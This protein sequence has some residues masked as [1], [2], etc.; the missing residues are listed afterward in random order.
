MRTKNKK[1]TV[2]ILALVPVFALAA[3]LVVSSLTTS[4]VQ[5]V[6]AQGFDPG[7]A[8][9]DL[10]KCEIDIVDGGTIHGSAC[11]TTGDSVD[12]IFYHTAAVAAGVRV[13]V[14]GGNDYPDV[15]ASSIQSK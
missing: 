5:N 14:T 6:E 8:D 2:P 12:V 11:T 4:G 7:A 1:W 3:F 15:Q 13:Y 10:K 9:N